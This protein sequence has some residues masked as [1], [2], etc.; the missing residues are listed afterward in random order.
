MAVYNEILAGRFNR[1]IQKLFS[2][3]GPPPVPQLASEIIPVLDVDFLMALENRILLGTR[4]FAYNKFQAAG[5][6]GNLGQVK[7]RNPVSSGVVATVEKIFFQDSSAAVNTFAVKGGPVGGAQTDLGTIDSGN[8]AIRDARLGAINGALVVSFASQAAVSAT[9]FL[10]T[11][12]VP[13]NSA[14]DVILYESQ[15]ISILP[16]DSITCFDSQ[17]NAAFAVTVFWRERVLEE[18][19]LIG[20]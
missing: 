10:W 7:L 15:E 5:G 19:E 17:A 8:S 18:S 6:A 1:A 2:M 9:R 11:T 4:S 14:A 13:A 3:K 12:A 16:G 20:A